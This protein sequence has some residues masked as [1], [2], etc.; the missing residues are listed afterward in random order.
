MPTEIV[1]ACR[2]GTKWTAPLSTSTPDPCPNGQKMTA[3]QIDYAAANESHFDLSG[4]TTVFMV[5]FSSVI[6]CFLAA[7]GV[8]ILISAIKNW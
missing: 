1:I 6:F 7:K 3:V 5:A 4:N 8:G 2:Q